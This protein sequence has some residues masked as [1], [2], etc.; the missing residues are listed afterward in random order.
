MLFIDSDNLSFSFR[1][2]KVVIQKIAEMKDKGETLA[3]ASLTV[4][5]IERGLRAD[6][7]PR[8]ESAFRD[9]LAVT[10][11]FPLDDKAISIAADIYADLK[12]RGKL[13]GEIDILIAA[14]VIRNN[15]TLFTNNIRHF[16]VVPNLKLL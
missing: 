5:E 10:D 3:L 15:G 4:Y 1:G 13:I 11:I 12:K 16:E 7:R 6:P 8:I 14:I 9:V 2:D